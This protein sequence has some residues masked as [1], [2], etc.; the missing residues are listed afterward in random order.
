MAKMK[1]NFDFKEF[2]LKKGERIALIGAGA[3]AALLILFGFIINGLGSGSASANA[4]DLAKLRQAGDQALKR[5]T[6]PQDLAVIPAD[7]FRAGELVVLDPTPFHAGK[8]YFMPSLADDN[9]WRKPEV[10]TPDEFQVDLVRGLARSLMFDSSKKSIMFLVSKDKGKNQLQTTPGGSGSGMG[11][12]SRMM[13]RFGRGGG[14]MGGGGMAGGADLGGDA[15]GGGMMSGAMPGDPS[16]AQGM[17]PE[18]RTEHMDLTPVPLDRLAK[19]DVNVPGTPAETTIPLRMA[20]VQ[21][22]FPLKKQM[23]EFRRALRYQYFWQM[24]QE[25]T[26]Q[27]AGLKV[28][29][30]TYRPNGKVEKEWEVL[31]LLTALKPYLMLESEPEDPRLMGYGIVWPL[32]RLVVPRPSLARAEKYP[33]MKLE[34]VK[35]TV[36]E[37]DKRS[38]L[39]ILTPIVNRKFSGEAGFD[40]F[41]NMGGGMQGMGMGMSQPGMPSGSDEALGGSSGNFKGRGPMQR[42]GMPGSAP[43]GI[44]APGMASGMNPS[45]GGIIPGDIMSRMNPQMAAMMS[46]TSG[47]AGANLTSFNGQDRDYPEKALVRFQDPTVKP[48]FVYQYRISIRMRNPLHNKEDKAIAKTMAKDEEIASKPVTIEKK[49]AVT[50]EFEYFFVIEDRNKGRTQADSTFVQIERWLDWTRNDVQSGSPVPVGDWTVARQVRV[51]KGEYIGRIEDQEV[52]MWWPQLEQFIFAARPD[53]KKLRQR[54]RRGIPVDFNTQ[55]VLVDFQGGQQKHPR[56]DGQP[57]EDN[58]ELD[59]LVLTRDGRLVVR[60]SLDDTENKER[61][62]RL[63]Y[64]DGWIKEVREA[65]EQRS[66]PQQ[67]GMGPGGMAPGGASGQAPGRDS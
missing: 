46:G 42:P 57:V 44:M 5:S 52:P 48:G 56:K 49:L 59:A 37:L 28:E 6:P 10:L 36:A 7:L 67:P 2:L 50:P 13:N 34:S 27:F 17:I 15:P 24:E 40:D 26:P 63:D 43:G 25:I 60:N 55:D 16:G 51:H 23:E 66:R 11:Q 65:K 20:V 41:W 1:L 3:F 38:Q 64:W 8:Q 61:R 45:Y 33:E 29:R 30:I 9:K 14:S 22:A 53:A 12:Y 58:S 18:G 35:N 32:D 31:D 39:P 62:E 54:G 47:A 4:G 19:G 21:G